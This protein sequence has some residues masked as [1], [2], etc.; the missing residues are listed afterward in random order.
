MMLASL[1]KSLRFKHR[2]LYSINFK[3]DLKLVLK[4]QQIQTVI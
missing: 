4:L 2:Y 1:N 3:L